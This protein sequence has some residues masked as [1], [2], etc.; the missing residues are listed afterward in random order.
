MTVPTVNEQFRLFRQ[1]RRQ[2]ALDGHEHQHAIMCRQ[3]LVFLVPLTGQSLDMPF[4][5][6]HELTTADFPFSLVT[7][8]DQPLIADERYPRVNDH[9]PPLG[10]LDDD[11]GSLNSAGI[12]LETQAAPLQD[13]LP[14]L[15]KPCSLEDPLECQLAPPAA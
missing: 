3:L 13:V 12:A 15:G 2:R 14:A 8:F 6:A 11:I 10:K 5:V 7:G 9:R 4:D 1:R